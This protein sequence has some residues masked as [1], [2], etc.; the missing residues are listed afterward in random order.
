VQWCRFGLACSVLL[1]TLLAV[2]SALWF[3]LLPVLLAVCGFT[4]SVIGAIPVDHQED[5]RRTLV[6]HGVAA[7]A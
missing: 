1:H 3:V 2:Q 7:A 5:T 6:S 4:G